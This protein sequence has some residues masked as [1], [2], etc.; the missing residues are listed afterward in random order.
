MSDDSKKEE[1]KTSALPVCLYIGE[2]EGFYLK[3]REALSAKGFKFDFHKK[4]EKDPAKVQ[5]IM[6]LIHRLRPVILLLDLSTNQ[7]E[8]LHL[9]RNQMRIHTMLKRHMISLVGHIDGKVMTQQAV[10]AGCKSVH[11]KTDDVDPIVFH[12]IAHYDPEKLNDHGFAVAQMEDDLSLFFPAKVSVLSAGGVRLETNFKVTPE[13]NYMLHSY[14]SGMKYLPGARVK[15]RSLDQSDIF[16]NFN[17]VEELAFLFKSPFD[18]EGLSEDEIEQKRKENE[19]QAIE[20]K[21]KMKNWVA[22]NFERSSPKLIKILVVD[23]EMTLFNE[24]EMTDSYP[25]I[26]RSQPYLKKVKHEFSTVYPQMIV[27]QFEEVDEEERKANDDIGFMYNDDRNLKH[28]IKTI[29]SMDQYFPFVV[30]FNS[31]FDTKKLKHELD[32]QQIVSYKEPLNSPLILK[33]AQILEK[34]LYNGE[35]PFDNNVV[36]LGKEMPETY[37]EFEVSCR[38]LGLTETDIYFETDEPI[39]PYAVL[40]FRQPAPFYV[41]IIDMPAFGHVQTKYYGII[42]GLSEDDRM[43]VRR[44]INSVFFR[45]KEAAKVAEKQEVDAIKQKYIDDEMKR[46]Q[47]QEVAKAEAEAKKKEEEARKEAEKQAL[48]DAAEAI[49]GGVPTD[50]AS[51][52]VEKEKAPVPAPEKKEE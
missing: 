24:K 20:Y 45:E 13:K 49:G 36:V 6:G 1:E 19:E 47:G 35:S 11:L 4:T 3:Y 34:K 29:K 18:K 44:Y 9:L 15:A 16:Y 41:T 51:S 23:K 42:H 2:D 33:M 43:E 32:Y 30:V 12:T 10:M 22:E 7:Q 25:Y 40:H 52:E 50:E 8:M 46:L 38:V 31:P 14:W 48:E 5:S 27:F 37:C 26:I 17:Y 28:F 21:E 39:D